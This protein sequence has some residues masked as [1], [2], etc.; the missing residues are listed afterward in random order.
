[1]ARKQEIPVYL[2]LG[3]LESGKT[4]VIQETMEDERFNTGEK[5]L[6]ILCEEGECEYDKSKFYGQNV[7]FMTIEN[8]SD[9]TPE[10]LGAWQLHHKLDRVII[11]YNGMWQ[12]NTLFENMPDSWFIFQ[13][14]MFADATTIAAYN[15]N[16]RSLVFDKISNAET[17]I[18]NR[19]SESTDRELLHRIVRETGNR[20]AQIIFETLDREIE[21]DEIEDPLPFDKEADVIEIEDRDYALFYQ[22][23]SEDLMSYNGKKVKFKG[24][25]ARDPRLGSQSFIIGRHVMTCCADDIQFSGLIAVYKTQS[26]ADVPL[27]N[28]DWIVVEGEIRIEKHKLYKNKGPVLYATSYAATSKPV[29]EVVTF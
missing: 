6:I 22:D 26:G 13:C 2:F 17:V 10:T 23:L 16:M 9:V 24:I 20:S 12:L 28:R 3:F 7:E 1:M 21:Y 18:F 25:V 15:A 29:Q 4:S 5:T 27:R 14:M 8:E 11:E 19:T